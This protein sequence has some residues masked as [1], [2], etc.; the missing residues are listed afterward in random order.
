MS[1]YQKIQVI[2]NNAVSLSIP[3]SSATTKDASGL[4]MGVSPKPFVPRKCPRRHRNRTS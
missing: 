3:M 2:I 1:H 4:L